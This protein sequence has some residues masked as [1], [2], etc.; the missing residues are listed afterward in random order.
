MQIARLAS[1]FVFDAYGTLFDV[2]SVTARAE[3]SRRGHGASLSQ[4]WRTKQLEY[5]WLQSLM[6]AIGAAARRLRGDHGACARLRRLAADG[7]AWRQ[8]DRQRLLDGYR[9]ARAVS[10]CTRRARRARAAPA[11]DPVQR[12]AC[13]AG[14]AGCGIGARRRTS[15][16]SCPSTLPASTSRAR[17]SIELAVD[18]LQLDRPRIGFVSSNGWDAWAPRP[19]ASRRSGSTATASPSSVMRG[20]RISSWARSR[21]SCRSRRCERRAGS[22]LPTIRRSPAG[23]GH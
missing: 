4:L 12:H 5:T 3:R 22:D 11:L 10:R 13:D 17:A 18:R 21:T 9:I 2:H 8:V 14:A 20:N 7:A 16:A 23:R 15:T 1:R 19:S 6:I